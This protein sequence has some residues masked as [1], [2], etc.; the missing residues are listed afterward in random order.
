MKILLAVDGSEHSLRAASHVILLVQGCASRHV[1]LL[2][3]QEPID[4]PELRS[5]L[6]EREIVAMQETRGGDALAGVRELLD[7][8]G[9]VNEPE[10]AIGAVAE[11]IAARARER[12]CDAIVMGSHGAG[13]ITSMLLGSVTSDVIRMSSCP[14]TV[15]R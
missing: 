7:K 13:T 6:P 14:V 2:N 11:T 1:H 9:V 5:H 15:V 3:V 4:A 12:G 8:A 10:V